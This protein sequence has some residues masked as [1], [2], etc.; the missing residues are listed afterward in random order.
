M[1]GSDALRRAGLVNRVR[2]DLA[3]WEFI[4]NCHNPAGPGGG[5]FCGKG[6][7]DFSDTFDGFF[8]PNG[9]AD[10]N[11]DITI[12]G[13]LALSEIDKIHGLEPDWP[14]VIAMVDNGEWLGADEGSLGAYMPPEP[15][16]EDAGSD[17]GRVVFR[18]TD[19]MGQ[20]ATTLVHELGHH[21]TLGKGV[22]AFHAEMERPGPL[23]D[24]MVALE[25][26]RTGQD[27]RE[28]NDKLT[29]A[30]AKGKPVED[31]KGFVEYL[32]MPEEMFA[33]AY[34]QYISI[35]SGRASMVQAINDS[36]IDPN[37]GGIMQWPPE[38]FGPISDAMDKYLRNRGL[39]KE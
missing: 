5:Q 19:N 22:D 20:M 10:K 17:R 8:D 13:G 2:R 37:D 23:R 27:L 30:V 6:I 26:S 38:E 15:I 9:L 29:A 35:K 28:I 36:L 3:N 39:L 25:E 34:A 1:R 4:N 12:A 33:R 32:R 11:K 14:K 24:L 7:G 21:L 16:T 18:S 31:Q